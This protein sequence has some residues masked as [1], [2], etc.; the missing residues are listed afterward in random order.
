[1]NDVYKQI[2]NL[3]FTFKHVNESGAKFIFHSMMDVEEMMSGAE[4]KSPCPKEWAIQHLPPP[5]TQK[6]KLM[7]SISVI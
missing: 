3:H 6:K 5:P 1:M 7:Q 4:R 2:L